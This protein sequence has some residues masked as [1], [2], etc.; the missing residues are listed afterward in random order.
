MTLDMQTLSEIAVFSIIVISIIAVLIQALL[1]YLSQR[2]LN[3]LHSM[4]IQAIIG[5]NEMVIV[6][7]AMDRRNRKLGDSEKKMN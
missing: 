5:V 2:N 4:G 3:D 7:E 1:S 6:D